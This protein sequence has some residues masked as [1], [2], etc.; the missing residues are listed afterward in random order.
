MYTSVPPCT[1]RDSPPR[2]TVSKQ[3]IVV[4]SY[5]QWGREREEEG[6][7]GGGEGRGGSEE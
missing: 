1:Y 3:T 6:K 2:S 7:G 4:T 5:M